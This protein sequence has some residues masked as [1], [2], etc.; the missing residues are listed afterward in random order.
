[1]VARML[2][3]HAPRLLWQL[4]RQLR[5]KRQVPSTA[6]KQQVPPVTTR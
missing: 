6:G 4:P 3:C 2:V 5:A 1:V